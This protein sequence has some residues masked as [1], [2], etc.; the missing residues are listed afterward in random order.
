MKNKRKV[1]FVLMLIL[2]ASP[3]LP[4]GASSSS[5]INLA[6]GKTYTIEYESPIENGFPKLVHNDE[7]NKLTDGRKAS[8]STSDENWLKLYRGTSIILTVDLGAICSVNRISLGQLHAYG[9]AIFAS[10]YVY[11]AVSEDGESY[12]TVG[13][14][15]DKQTVTQNTTT[16]LTHNFE[17]GKYYKA[18][19]V[20]IIL[21]SDVWTMIDE[22][23]VFGSTD[24]GLGESAQPDE[25]KEYTDSV[26]TDVEGLRNILVMYSGQYYSV[27]A[28]ST[29]M[30]TYSQLLPYFTY[31]DKSHEPIDTLFD[32]ML[33]LPLHPAGDAEP[34]A[35]HTFHK[36]T[37]WEIYLN[38]TL[39]VEDDA[40]I[41]ALDK[42]VGDYKENLGLGADYKYPIY[43]SVPYIE[44]SN[45]EVFGTINGEMLTPSDFDSRIKIVKW[46]V[47]LV[48][49][50]FDAAGFENIKLNGLYWHHE[51]VPYNKSNYEDELIKAFNAYV[52]SKGGYSTIWIPYYQAPGFE[53]WRE[54]GFDAAVLQSGYAFIRQGADQTGEKLPGVV[55]DSLALAKKYGLGMEIETSG[56]LSSGDEEGFYRYQK[57]LN[58][59]YRNGLMDN[60]LMM[61]YQD[62]GPG[63]FF[64]CAYSNNAR[65]REG[66][67]LTY[68]F[69]K[70]AYT[71]FA[72]VIQE[73]QFLI[74]KK[75]TSVSGNLVITDEDTAVGALKSVERVTCEN[76]VLSVDGSFMIINAKGD[77][78]GIETFVHQVTDG[79][80]E[81]NIVTVTI[82]VVEDRIP[83]RYINEGLRDNTAGV[84]N[85][86]GT[87][88]GTD[89]TALEVLVGADGKIISVGGYNNTVPDGGYIIAAKGDAQQ[90]IKNNAKTG[91]GV[92]YDTITGAIV[93]IA[94]DGTII[95]NSELQEETT[96]TP[97]SEKSNLLWFIIGA[98]LLAIAGIS[99]AIII[100]AK[101]KTKKGVAQ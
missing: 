47:D 80:N 77:F 96:D 30:N 75:G 6:R 61:Y 56:Y 46:F 27:V 22:L 76:V 62:G 51:L 4:L 89:D 42:L 72:P 49:S 101:A 78:L 52:K 45:S 36:K 13:E 40:N 48:L 69:I 12:A 16:K 98:G 29:G 5:D 25:P 74:V 41:A 38:S 65:A 21:S 15:T 2:L 19:Y 87:A 64:R 39:G 9:P 32:G 34:M 67:D 90:Y 59:A 18:R 91:L 58:S 54:L 7:H 84:F 11:A 55:D 94:D 86:S 8:A 35:D 20:R 60:G 10:R 1:C 23:E 17:L 3:I 71:S 33:F 44:I 99:A 73:N 85:A 68:S 82:Y 50:S 70:K 93:F 63:A 57:Y 100:K 81:S 92:M 26:P 88:T 24:A 79:F 97:Y 37:G 53:T 66:Y 31:I 14:K 95:H 28:A 83:I 43:I